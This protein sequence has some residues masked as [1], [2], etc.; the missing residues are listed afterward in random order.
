MNPSKSIS[1][2]TL[3]RGAGTSVALPLLDAMVPAFASPS[4][5]S[6]RRMA[7]VYVPN[8]IIMDQWTPQTEGE[9]ARL[10]EALPRILKPLERFRED[11]SVIS[12]L[13]LH[14]AEELGDGPGDH[15]RAA[16]AYL[17]GA[18][19]KKTAGADMQNAVSVDQIAAQQVGK[20]TRFAS[21]ELSCE[22]GILGGN[23][24]NGYS[25][26]YSNSISW[27]TPSNPLPPE[28]N[29][30]ALF[31]RLFGGGDVEQD[32]VRRAQVQEYD[33]SVLDFVLDDAKRLQGELGATDRRKLDEYLFAVRDVEERILNAERNAPVLPP[34]SIKPAA[35]IPDNFTEHSRLM[36]DLMTLALQTDSTR[37]CTLMFGI[38][39][40]NRNYREIGVS[41][42]HHGLSHHRGDKEKI[43]KLTLINQFHM[44]QFAYGLEKLQSIQDGDG[45]LL[46]HTMLLY[47]AGI[48]DG[49]KHLHSNLPVLLAGR[50]FSMR[51]GYHVNYDKL[52]PMTNLYLS[53][54]DQMGVPCESITDSTGRLQYQVGA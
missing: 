52:V 5:T 14:G 17:T 1:R 30:R 48:S 42:A 33:R 43:E 11:V 12:G 4:P 7:F 6:P 26:A 28:S 2:R 49:N 21:L 44:E 31:E 16:A 29:P 39:I 32:P 23:C 27:R 35:G 25:C 8:G 54:L 9:V 40:S 3:L 19:P 38:E 47:G 20:E 22:E 34:G 50:G 36:F 51:P 37:V 18:H 53:M 15:A 45:S 41:E 46:D 13:N 10:P 24:D